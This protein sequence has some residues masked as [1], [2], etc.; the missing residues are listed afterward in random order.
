[1]GCLFSSSKEEGLT[2]ARSID[3]AAPAEISWDVLCDIDSAPEIYYPVV[4][5]FE[6]I[7]GTPAGFKVGTSWKETRSYGGRRPIVQLL[8]V[9]NIQEEQDGSRRAA[10]VQINF[11]NARGQ[12]A[13]DMHHTA[14]LTVQRIDDTHCVVVQS[15]AF[16]GFGTCW[17]R[18]VGQCFLKWVG[19]EMDK[20]M[21]QLA[22]EVDRRYQH[23]QEGERSDE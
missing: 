3:I 16:V 21:Q 6:R 2:L 23:Q 15:M 5:H 19:G 4:T 12:F 9:V 18:M 8:T 22:G 13:A 20:Q 10:T 7:Q 14:T 1:M 11:Y 17:E